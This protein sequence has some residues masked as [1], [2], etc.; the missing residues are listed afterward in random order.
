METNCQSILSPFA[1]IM[2]PPPLVSVLIPSYNHAPYLTER[3][4]SIIYQTYQNY[5]LIIIDDHSNDGSK[6]ILST[7]KALHSFEYIDNKKNSGTPFSAWERIGKIAKGQYI[8]ICES[9]DVADPLF[10]EGAIARLINNP[11]AVLFYSNSWVIDA[12]SKVVGDTEKY[13]HENWNTDRWKQDFSSSGLSELTAY[14]ISGQTVPNMS[15]AVIRSD[16]FRSAFTP[17]LKSFR[18]TGDWIFIGDVM[19]FGDVEFCHEKLSYFR[20]HEQTSRVRVQS[21]RSQ[22][23]FILTKFW[24]FKRS[25]LH[26]KDFAFVM[27]SDVIRF[28]YES[29]SWWS[30]LRVAIKISCLETM[31]CAVMLL[32]ST[33][34]NPF[35]FKKFM[36]RYRHAKH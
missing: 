16:A 29:E 25:N 7:L 36:E 20:M 11:A 21:A 10:L 4:K 22:A 6:E 1:R 35:Y 34:F 8:W 28:L 13:F 18:L 33:I 2:T 32:A 24:L 30:V 19:R 14:Q 31:Q 26:F 5:E 9:D 27:R 17:Y 15:S 3:I 12:S 23:E